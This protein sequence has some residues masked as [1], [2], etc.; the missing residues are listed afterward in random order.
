[1]SVRRQVLGKELVI[2][3]LVGRMVLVVEGVV[4]RVI[5]GSQLVSGVIWRDLRL[6]LIGSRIDGE[7]ILLRIMLT[8]I[9]LVVVGIVVRHWVERN[10]P[11]SM[12]HFL[13]IR[14]L[15]G[16]EI[17]IVQWVHGHCHPPR[18]ALSPMWRNI[19]VRPPL[20]KLHSTDI[21]PCSRMRLYPPALHVHHDH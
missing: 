5:E 12:E 11:S 9:Q 15:S 2:L 20:R 1:M 3:L 8:G 14:V 18:R 17:S 13:G 6:E 4:I 16:D 19:D 7:T 21:S 10:G